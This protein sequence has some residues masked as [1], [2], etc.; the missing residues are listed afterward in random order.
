MNILYPSMYTWT[1]TAYVNVYMDYN[2]ILQCI[3]GLLIVAMVTLTL[4]TLIEEGRSCSVLTQR[5]SLYMNMHN[6]MHNVMRHVEHALQSSNT[7]GLLLVLCSMICQ[8]KS[9][10]IYGNITHHVM[11]T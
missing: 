2:C 11:K 5:D 9:T 8:V 4:V 7:R 1:I 3:L 6:V 10:Y